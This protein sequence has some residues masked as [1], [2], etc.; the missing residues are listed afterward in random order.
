MKVSEKKR[1]DEE[2][3]GYNFV[4]DKMPLFTERET[5]LV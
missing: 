5:G 2:N 3:F 4:F 1:R